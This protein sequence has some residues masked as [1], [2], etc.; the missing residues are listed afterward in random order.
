MTTDTN[1]LYKTPSPVTAKRRLSNYP[2]EARAVTEK[3]D[4]VNRRLSDY[5]VQR[6]KKELLEEQVPAARRNSIDIANDLLG[7]VKEA[8]SIDSTMG[9]RELERV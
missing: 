8:D 1:L 5:A 4:R 9:F 7:D 2:H 6:V 3:T